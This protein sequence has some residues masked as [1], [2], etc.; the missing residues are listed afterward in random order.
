MFGPGEIKQR[1]KG[2]TLVEMMVALFLG[3]IA[4]VGI[5]KTYVAYSTAADNQGQ[6]QEL[7]QNLR[8][9][10]AMMVRD[11]RM[12]G[13]DPT[14]IGGIGFEEA[15]TH[16]IQFRMDINQDG[17][18]ADDNEDIKYFIKD[19]DGD[20]FF[21]LARHNVNTGVEEYINENIDPV[22][23]IAGEYP[24]NFVFMEGI[25]VLP[26][27]VTGSDRDRIRSVE[28]ALVL[29]STNEDYSFKNTN[30]YNNLQGLQIL[31]AKNDNFYRRLTTAKVNC[32]N[33][34]LDD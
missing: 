19:I 10:M 29:R 17:D 33:M 21:G 13:F 27:P 6:A 7:Q 5:Y 15:T 34:G 23:I 28:I 25:T 32:R 8:V 24:L 12:A 30:S 2:F 20:G 18:V 4:M 11:I 16:K 14:E 31:P 26:T 3:I 1:N 22:N 9:S